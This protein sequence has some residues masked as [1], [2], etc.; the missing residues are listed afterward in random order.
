MALSCALLIVGLLA[1]AE[2]QPTSTTITCVEIPDPDPLPTLSGLLEPPWPSRLL[3][4]I[5][6]D[7]TVQVVAPSVQYDAPFVHV[8]YRQQPIFQQRGENYLLSRGGRHV[9]SLSDDDQDGAVDSLA[10][11][12]WNDKPPVHT[13]VVDRGFD[14]VADVRAVRESMDESSVFWV[15][16]EDAW[17]KQVGP[18]LALVDGTPTPYEVREGR[19][20][21]V[22]PL[23]Q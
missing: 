9:V 23:H 20:F 5:I 13:F 8:A 1:A 18:R 2:A 4:C 6:G 11:E 10:Y 16:V 22:E 15:W 14:G 12:I 17:Y 7:Y 3:S 21:F 19:F